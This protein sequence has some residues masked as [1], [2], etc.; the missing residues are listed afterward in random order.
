MYTLVELVLN[1]AFQF[2]KNNFDL[3]HTKK[4]TPIDSIRQV[5]TLLLSD[6]KCGRGGGKLMS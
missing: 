3:I 2:A 4:L 1:S 6:E 5:Y